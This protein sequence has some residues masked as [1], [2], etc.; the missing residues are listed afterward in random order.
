MGLVGGDENFVVVG[1]AEGFEVGKQAMLVG[2]RETDAGDRLA[3]F[4]DGLAHGVQGVLDGLALVRGEGLDE[5]FTDTVAERAVVGAD[6]PRSTE[7]PKGQPLLA[8]RSS[9]RASYEVVARR[10]CIA[11]NGKVC[12][13]QARHIEARAQI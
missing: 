10:R 5:E 6:Q 7:D 1:H 8:A 11:S 2:H 13:Q 4:Q 9:R 3:G 12:I